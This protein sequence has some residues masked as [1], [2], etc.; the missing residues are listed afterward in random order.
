MRCVADLNSGSCCSCF[1]ERLG[2]NAPINE[3]VCSSI[4]ADLNTDGME[5]GDGE[6]S[7]FNAI[8]C[9]TVQI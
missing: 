4:C 3:D 5:D 6:R 7:L 9:V 8:S 2:E 1:A